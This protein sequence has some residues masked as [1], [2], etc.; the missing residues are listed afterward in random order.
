MF[1][2]VGLFFILFAYVP[3]AGIIVA[4]KN[5]TFSGGIWESDWNGFTN[6]KFLFISGKL[7]Q[8]TRN[9][10]LYNI[11]NL[12]AYT[13]F[14]VL[15]AVMI[16][17]IASKWFKK[18]TQ[19][20]L[21]LPYF[22]SWVVVAGLMYN[23]FSADAGLINHVL[24]PLGMPSF[25]IYMHPGAWPY[26]LVILYVWKWVGYGSV[27]Y[28][29]AIMG[30]DQEC[31]EAATIDGCNIYQRIRHITLPLL[32]P[33]IVILM[34]LA[35]GGLMR[36]QFDMVYNLVGQNSNLFPITDNIDILVFKA[37]MQTQNFGMASAGAFYQSV[38]CFLIIL[39]VNG[40]ARKIDK[41]YA[42][43]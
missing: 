26:V 21:F 13:F 5:Y 30:I 17:E 11:A 34:L 20:L 32:K 40:I 36:G 23:L 6:F 15:L 16:A 27:L 19:S 28:L 24:V 35:I 22:I 4:F 1:L 39:V 37:L 31:Y 18:I 43:F 41:D 33:T 2:P 10:I 29:S 7:W 3:M 9:T 42:L 25:D 14:S 38:L 12:V 8:V